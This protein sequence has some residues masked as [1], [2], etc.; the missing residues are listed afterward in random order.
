MSGGPTSESDAFALTML[1]VVICGF[2][3]V[4]LLLVTIL[5]NASK[6]NREDD[7]LIDEVEKRGDDTNAAVGKTSKH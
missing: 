3:I 6:R 7:D 2:G 4:V 5:R 1:A